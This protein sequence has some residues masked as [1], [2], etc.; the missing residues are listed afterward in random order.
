MYVY[1][2]VENAKRRVSSCVSG[3]DELLSGGYVKARSTLLASGPSSR[4]SILIWWILFDGV[5]KESEILF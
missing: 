5:K 4:K 2:C 3:L 1:Y